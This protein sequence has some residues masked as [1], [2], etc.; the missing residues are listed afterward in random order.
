[1][2]NTFSPP[3]SGSG[4]IP[5]PDAVVSGQIIQANTI[6]RLANMINYTHAQLGCSP[7]VSQGWPDGVFA[8]QAPQQHH[9]LCRY[10][11]CL[12]PCSFMFRRTTAA[13]RS[14][15]LKNPPT[16]TQHN[17]PHLHQGG[18]RHPLCG[19]A[20]THLEITATADAT[21]GT[22]TISYLSLQ[23][24]PL[25]SPLAAGVVDSKHSS[26]DITP[27][28]AN[29]SA[30]DNP[31]SAARGVA[32]TNTLRELAQRPRVFFAWSGLQNVAPVTAPKTLLPGDF[33]SKSALSRKWG[34]SRAREHEYQAHIYAATHGNGHDRDIVWRDQ[35]STVPAAQ[36]VPAGRLSPLMSDESG[37]PP[38]ADLELLR[39]G[40]RQQRVRKS[41][42]ITYL[43]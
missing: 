32:V 7:V 17:Q 18:M 19:C 12:K 22:T 30:A 21:A 23:W 16:T 35:R 24:Q 5:S 31:L 20:T 9:A 6:S 26:S 41:T 28:G 4:L 43:V 8:I 15:T 38:A 39:D 40:P 42:C 33:T 13:M 11:H 2:G 29:R 10:H 25:A 14:I 27:M 1:M 34:G 3:T 36:I 37:R